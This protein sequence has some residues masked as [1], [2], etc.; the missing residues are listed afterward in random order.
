MKIDAHL[1]RSEEILLRRR[2]W[3]PRLFLSQ[4]VGPLI[5]VESPC[6]LCG[7][8][9]AYLGREES[10]ERC[11]TLVCVSC[12][13]IYASPR[14]SPSEL[15]ILNLQNPGDAGS[16]ASAP[17]GFL[18]EKDLRLED[19]VA[20]WASKVIERFTPIEGK[21]VLSLRCLSGALAATLRRKGAN[22]YAVDPFETNIRHARRERGLSETLTIPMSGFHELNLPWNSQFDVIEGLSVHVLAHVMYPRRLLSRIRDLLKPGGYLFLDEKDVLLPAPRF[23]DF[24]L[25]TGRAHQHQLSLQTTARYVRSIGFELLECQIDQERVSGFHHIRVVARKP[26]FEPAAGT[27][28]PVEAG[29]QD[30]R[31]I[32]RQ[33][34][35]LA[36]AVWL[37]R[38][39]KTL[40]ARSRHALT[41]IP[42]LRHIW[43]SSP[44]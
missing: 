32:V 44:N 23:D 3:L 20:L 35:R 16:L 33:L 7:A 12:G 17:S 2:S 29:G 4:F 39:R 21:S 43:H 36:W 11:R 30:G 41:Q 1:T 22:V 28:P 5:T 27:S 14:P 38:Q 24:V 6:D 34:Q 25:D 40:S 31:E 42:G 19:R 37:R 18:D 10:P 26:P 13:L 8:S 15:D 9:E